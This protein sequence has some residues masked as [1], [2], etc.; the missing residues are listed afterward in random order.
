MADGKVIYEVRA[1]DSNLNNDLDNSNKKVEKGTSKLAANASKTSAV[2]G[3]SFLAIGAAAVGI[4]ISS[5]KSANN[6]DVAMNSFI[7]STGIAASET[8]R[9]Q[10]V[11]E[12]IYANNYG[13]S[14]DDISASLAVVK[15]NMGELND[16]DLQSVTESAYALRD[17]FGF[18]IPESTRAAQAMIKNFGTDGKTAMSMIA[19]GAQNGLDFSGELL[20]SISEYSVQFSKV[21]LNADDMFNIFQSGADNG[22]WNIDKIGDAVKEFSIRSVDGSKTTSEGFKQLGLDA[23]NMTAKFGAGGE[24]AKAAFNET[25][26]ALA[27]MKDPIA[28]NAAGVALFGTQWEDL[29]PQVITQ[30]AG[31][32]SGA[33]DAAG[34]MD[35]IKKVKYND[36]GSMLEGLGRTLEV[37]LIP[38]GEELIP[39]ISDV[40]NAI[41]PIIKDLLPVIMERVSKLFDMIMP[42]LSEVAET[43]MDIF[44]Q[45]WDGISPI[46]DDILP[47]LL[48]LFLELWNQLTPMIE[49]ILPV[50]IELFQELAPA[51]MTIIEAILPPLL[52]LVSALLPIFLQLV[53]ALIP[54]I[55]L[56]LQLLE[57][58]VNLIESALVPLIA[59][60]EP[61]ISILLDVLV[62]VLQIVL[63]AFTEVFGGILSF[64]TGQVSLLTGVLGSMI[65]FIKNVF[66]G[67]WSA[68]WQNVKDIFSNIASGLG[69]I[70]KFPINIIIDLMNGFISGLNM[71]KIPDW[72]PGVGG[73]GIDI[74]EIPRL[75]VGMDYVPSD[76]FPA[77]LDEGEAVLTKSEAN[78]WR[79]MSGN[80]KNLSEP[81][82]SSNSGINMQ[83]MSISKT[84]IKDAFKE[85]IKDVPATDTV[86]ILG[87]EEVARASNKGNLAIEMRYGK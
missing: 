72:V 82:N 21:G 85:A 10:G 19:A 29:G 6:M 23:D 40:I 30:L 59:I 26:K 31:I 57:P 47:R 39:V 71:I 5:V 64:V 46:V 15:K 22:A 7:A 42:T 44:S 45:L 20:D 79:G 81:Y 80:L 4:G 16:T 35:G 8:E 83:G 9:Y 55:D 60:L 52:D 24:T 49:E 17:T 38:L 36:L 1:D 58:I 2:V 53:D 65:D 50:L 76:Y 68:A 87:N 48:D 56:F 70:F 33:Y 63:S 11:L 62:P 77:Y 66:T 78:I 69:N 84:D 75:K 51:I 13:D 12:N 18:D 73:K 25:I 14:F 34:A 27:G 28:Q 3:A 43:L 41:M 74:P 67:N 37:M 54:I 61:L 32:K 86:L